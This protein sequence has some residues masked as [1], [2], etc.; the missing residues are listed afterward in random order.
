MCDIQKFSTLLQ[1]RK[2]QSELTGIKFEMKVL[3][4]LTE[5]GPGGAE[6]VA[7]D[8]SERLLARS[9][10]V[11]LISLKSPPENKSMADAFLAMGIVPEFLHMDGIR[12]FSRIFLLRRRIRKLAPD[13]IHTHLMHPNLVTRPAAAGLGIPLLNTVH[14]SERRKHKGIFFWLDGLSFPLCSACNA[15]SFATARFH[16]QA[17]GLPAGTISVIYNGVD[18]IPRPD[19]ADLAGYRGKWGLDGCVKIIGAVGRLDWQKG[20][21]NLLRLLPELSAAIPSSERWGLVILGE[22]AQRGELE[23]LASNAPENLIVRLPG[24]LPD[25]SRM[26]WLFDVFVMPSRYEGYGLSLAEAMT[27]GVPVVVNPVDSLP[28]ICRFYRNH[29][30]TDFE[31]PERRS[32]TAQ[33]IVEFARHERIAPQ[34]ISTRREMADRYIKLY[35]KLLR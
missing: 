3:Q 17:I 19:P 20:F 14:I 13:I 33:R 21:D 25:A 1:N 18:P 10:S 27:T 2:C 7:L 16:E 9:H 6:R 28:E 34:V 12:D 32:E 4:I 31:S 5:L 26:N 30:L 29:I 15:V 22:G 23:E 35:D 11:S 24:F 8:L